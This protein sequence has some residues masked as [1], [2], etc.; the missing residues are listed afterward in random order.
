MSAKIWPIAEFSIA[1]IQ[2]SLNLNQLKEVKKEKETV[3][4]CWSQKDP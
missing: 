3:K 2:I 4:K 1:D